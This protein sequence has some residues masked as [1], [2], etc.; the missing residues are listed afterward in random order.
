MYKHFHIS[1]IQVSFT[2]SVKKNPLKSHTIAS[3]LKLYRTFFDAPIGNK[4]TREFNYHSIEAMR[5]NAKTQQWER[6]IGIMV[7][8]GR[9]TFYKI[10]DWS[11]SVFW[12]RALARIEFL[13]RLNWII[14][15]DQYFLKILNPSFRTWSRGMRHL[16]PFPVWITYR[17]V[18]LERRK[19]YRY[20]VDEV[21]IDYTV[22]PV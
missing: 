18:F 8:I 19:N 16:E 17:Y 15:L 22:K 2:A 10:P 11:L 12:H 6:N 21:H 4:L 9:W 7:I 20:F 1:W 5:K 13:T 14:I 3:H